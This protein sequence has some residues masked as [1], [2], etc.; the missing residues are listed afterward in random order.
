MWASGTA[1]PRVSSSGTRQATGKLRRRCRDA[2]S[3]SRPAAYKMLVL[4]QLSLP[5]NRELPIGPIFLR[6]PSLLR[7]CVLDSGL[8]EVPRS[9]GAAFAQVS[10]SSR[11]RAVLRVF[12]Y[13]STDI[14]DVRGEAIAATAIDSIEEPSWEKQMGHSDEYDCS[15]GNESR[16][17]EQGPLFQSPG[18]DH[19]GQP[20]AHV[21]LKFDP[22]ETLAAYKHLNA[23]LIRSG[24]GRM[25]PP[26]RVT[27]IGG[28]SHDGK[29]SHGKR[30]DAVRHRRAGSSAWSEEFCMSQ[31]PHCF[32]LLQRPIRPSRLWR[33]R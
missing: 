22:Q 8:G 18:R 15:C 14:G 1:P 19:M 12:E 33:Y 10:D 28:G 11:H 13:A 29:H 16:H 5:D 2:R 26:Q 20:I 4:L 32:R 24:L 17:R 27:I 31:V 23:Q 25:G 30:S 6:T 3:C 9:D 21:A 7:I